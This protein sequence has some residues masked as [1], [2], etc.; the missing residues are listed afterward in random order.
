MLRNLLSPIRARFDLS[1]PPRS[2]SL[3]L[4]YTPRTP[5]SPNLRRSRSRSSREEKDDGLEDF[6]RD[7]MV[8]LMRNAV[9]ILKTA[10]NVKV[11]TEAL[12]EIQRILVQDPR[13]KDVFRELD[14]LLV[15]MSVLST[16][17]EQPLSGASISRPQSLDSSPV[18]VVVVDEAPQ[19]V[20]EQQSLL[21]DVV[22][23]TRLV[24]MIL[25]EAMYKHPRNAEW[26]RVSH[27]Y[28]SAFPTLN[29]LPRHAL[30][31]NSYHTR[32]SVSYQ[33]RKQHQKH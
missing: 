11:K 13:T 15:L 23:S 28:F 10:E 19:E 22:E 1:T 8:E 6:A 7:V 9:E 25:S 3:P 16:V 24:F 5:R 32:R 12:A 2:S 30:A 20:D 14:G 21:A 27:Y 18:V 4:P 31:T 33:T 26:F 29:F 17:Q